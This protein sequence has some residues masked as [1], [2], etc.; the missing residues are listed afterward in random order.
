MAKFSTKFARR[1]LAALGIALTG[2][3]V[4]AQ[5]MPAQ[6][7]GS[8]Y[9]ASRT[10]WI[11]YTN[12]GYIGLNVGRS[13]YRNGCGLLAFRCDDGATSGH[14]Y[15]GGYFNPYLG[16]EIGYLD[17]GNI[18]I[19]GGTTT[20]NGLNLSLVGRVPLTPMFSIYGKLGA[21]YGRTRVSAAAGS[22]IATGR[23]SGWG[24]SYALGVSWDVSRNWSAVLEVERNRFEFAGN[25]N[26][27]VRSTSL[28]LK[29][30][31]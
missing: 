10:S 3:A 14:V 5:T 11:P 19:A 17:M 28:G 15:L 7:G 25:N 29:Y 9:D 1:T 20:A 2:F 13:D 31:F 23:E 30:S 24:P 22:G 27:Y 8:A 26:E 16:A 4:Q 21:T 6:T 18:D 12:N